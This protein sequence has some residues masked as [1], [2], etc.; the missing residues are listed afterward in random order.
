MMVRFYQTTKNTSNYQYIVCDCI[1]SIQFTFSI[2]I[3]A[4]VLFLKD[5]K[6]FCYKNR[7]MKLRSIDIIMCICTCTYSYT[8]TLIEYMYVLLITVCLSS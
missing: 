7:H 6:K 2:H 5:I 1:I 8:Y 3:S 4:S